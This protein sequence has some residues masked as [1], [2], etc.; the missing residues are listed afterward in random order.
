MTHLNAAQSSRIG[1]NLYFVLFVSKLAGQC[2]SKLQTH[3][4]FQV[5]DARWIMMSAFVHLSFLQTVLLDG[6]LWSSHNQV[7]EKWCNMQVLEGRGRRVSSVFWFQGLIF[8][9]KAAAAEKLIIK[10]LFSKRVQQRS[11]VSGQLVRTDSWLKVW[12]VWCDD[13]VPFRV[14][15]LFLFNSAGARLRP[16]GTGSCFRTRGPVVLRVAGW[17]G[18]K[19]SLHVM[20]NV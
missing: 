17:N 11:H 5:V 13:N 2:D 19:D 12:R 15:I 8:W 1:K 9:T 3:H 16:G 20:G 6:V 4:Q 18:A 10:K 7:E 14:L